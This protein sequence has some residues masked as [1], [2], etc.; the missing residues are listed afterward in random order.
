MRRAVA[1]D[2]WFDQHPLQIVWTV[3]VVPAEMPADHPLV[4]ATLDAGAGVGRPGRAAGLDS[5]HD[6]ATFT[7]RGGTPTFSYGADGLATAHTIDEWVLVDDLVDAA[8]VYALAAMRWCG[9]S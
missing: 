8:V 5:W 6:A 3:D 1:T 4:T 2:P 9:V 7:R